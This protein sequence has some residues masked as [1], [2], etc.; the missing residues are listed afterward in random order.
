MLKTIILFHFSIN[1]CFCITESINSVYIIYC[2][3]SDTLKHPA[4]VWTSVGRLDQLMS[5]FSQL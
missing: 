3:V 1:S 5:V 4:D 2:L